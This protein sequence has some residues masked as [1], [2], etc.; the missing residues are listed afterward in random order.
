MVKL[1]V[2]FSNIHKETKAVSWSEGPAFLQRLLQT[3]S[4]EMHKT[5]GEKEKKRFFFLPYFAGFCQ[6]SDLGLNIHCWIDCPCL[7]RPK[8][9]PSSWEEAASQSRAGHLLGSLEHK[10]FSN[11]YSL[12]FGRLDYVV[13]YPASWYREK[14]NRSQSCYP[15]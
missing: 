11:I 7:L 1:D 4:R 13:F 2:N 15:A 6:K 12:Q 8:W 14:H 3:L 9:K 10:E 5:P